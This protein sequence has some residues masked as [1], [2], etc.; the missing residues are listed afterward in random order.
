MLEGGFDGDHMVSIN[1]GFSVHRCPN[2]G[3]I[4]RD[5]QLNFA[6]RLG[7]AVT[8]DVDSRRRYPLFGVVREEID[9]SV[10]KRAVTRAFA[11]V[12]VFKEL[13]NITFDIGIVKVCVVVGEKCP[14]IRF[15]IIKPGTDEGS[16]GFGVLPT[17]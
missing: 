9:V 11:F 6:K 10:T 1:L 4:C 16:L 3:A 7:I 8:A 13:T 17:K 12:I 15:V 2:I 14:C 5:V